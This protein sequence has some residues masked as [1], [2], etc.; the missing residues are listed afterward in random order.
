MSRQCVAEYGRKFTT[1]RGK[2]ID[3][4]SSSMVLTDM[5]VESGMSF[6]SVCRFVNCTLQ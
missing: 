5:I 1:G 6:G 2:I 3:E 4:N